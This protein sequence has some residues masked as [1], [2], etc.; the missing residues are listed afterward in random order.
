MRW[1]IT[2][3]HFSHNRS[4]LDRVS[5]QLLLLYLIEAK[6]YNWTTASLLLHQNSCRKGLSFQGELPGHSFTMVKKPVFQ[7]VQQSQ[8]L[9]TVLHGSEGCF[10][11]GC[12]RLVCAWTP[13]Q[14]AVP[15]PLLENMSDLIFTDKKKSEQNLSVNFARAALILTIRLLLLLL[16]TM[17]TVLPWWEGTPP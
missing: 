2:G 8:L 3:D 11:T 1:K 16:L 10:T 17:L 6:L 9:L 5:Q 7:G 12:S 4:R 13:F 15:C 14:R